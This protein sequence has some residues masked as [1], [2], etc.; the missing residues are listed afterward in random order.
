VQ[1]GDFNIL[2]VQPE[3]L[4]TYKGHLPRLAQVLRNSQLPKMIK[5]VHVDEAHSIYTAGIPLYGQPAFRPAWGNLGELRLLLPKT[6]PVQALSGTFPPHITRC[7]T[8]KLL[9]LSDYVTIAL[10]SNRPNITYATHPI[11]GSLS[12]FR[13]LQFLVPEHGNKTFDPKFI[14]KTI[15]FF[16]NVQEATNATNYL[17]SLF[18][19]TMQHSRFVKHYHSKMSSEYLE[20]TF[21]DFASPDGTTRIL[22]ATSGASTVSGQI[23]LFFNWLLLLSC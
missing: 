7:V 21:Q 3:Q 6:I 12:N 18:P 4:Q 13:N 2:I 8:E 9:F 10:I 14:P 17:N 20:S 22:C 19:E 1:A 5:R 11:V 23:L 15:I 16:D